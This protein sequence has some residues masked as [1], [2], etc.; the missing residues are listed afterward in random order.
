ME[1]EL[2]KAI[3]LLLRL[4]LSE[5]QAEGMTED[6]KV[7]VAQLRVILDPVNVTKEKQGELHLT[8]LEGNDG[9]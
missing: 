9:K 3:N 8:P 4:W 2:K 7:T 6:E 1:T 5:R